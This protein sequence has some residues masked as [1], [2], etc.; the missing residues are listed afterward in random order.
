MLEKT[1]PDPVPNSFRSENAQESGFKNV[2]R[3]SGNSTTATVHGQEISAT[4]AISGEPRTDT[5]RSPQ[6]QKAPREPGR[7]VGT[8]NRCGHVPAVLRNVPFKAQERRPYII[9]KMLKAADR[10][11]NRSWGSK[12]G[13]GELIL[14]RSEGRESLVQFLKKAL[15]NLELSTMTIRNNDENFSKPTLQDMISDADK[16]GLSLSRAKRAHQVLVDGGYL[17]VVRSP[18]YA[19]G[20]FSS[21]ASERLV[22]PKLFKLLGLSQHE[23]SFQ[24][25][26]KMKR[27]EK[28]GL[29]LKQKEIFLKI[30][31]SFSSGQ[32]N[33]I[34]GVKTGSFPEN[35]QHRQRLVDLYF[36]LLQRTSPSVDVALLRAVAEKTATDNIISALKRHAPDTS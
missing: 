8:G 1:T 6:N 9:Q 25:H 21:D 20:E 15:Y 33:E 36:G 5:L 10:L 12:K 14:V 16:T 30:K 27:L 35:Q 22:T 3:T 32:K 34:K 31:E 13:H 24:Q 18:K 17:R 4:P 29:K 7:Y 28:K 19:N 2:Q 11:Y 26:Y 23:Y